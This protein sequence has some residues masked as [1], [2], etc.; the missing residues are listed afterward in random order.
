[1]KEVDDDSW[2]EPWYGKGGKKMI[3]WIENKMNEWS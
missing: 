2:K 3:K 1:V